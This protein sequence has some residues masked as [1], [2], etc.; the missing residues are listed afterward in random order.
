MRTLKTA[1]AGL[2][3]GTPYQIEEVEDLG[4]CVRWRGPEDKMTRV[5]KVGEV[6]TRA[7]LLYDAHVQSLGCNPEEPIPCGHCGTEIPACLTMCNECGMDPDGDE[8]CIDCDPD[9]AG[10]PSGY[11]NWFKAGISREEVCRSCNGAKVVEGVHAGQREAALARAR[12]WQASQRESPAPAEIG[13][14]R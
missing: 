8:P 2:P 13:G 1:V 14:G 10:Q 3:A 4:R 6:G 9:G 5:E 7:P 12:A 11:V